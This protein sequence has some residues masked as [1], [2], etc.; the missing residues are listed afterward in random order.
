M[1][2]RHTGRELLRWVRGE[3]ELQRSVS[4]AQLIRQRITAGKTQLRQ[5]QQS[6]DMTAKHH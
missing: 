2:N 5:L 4:D 3:F 1:D 6:L